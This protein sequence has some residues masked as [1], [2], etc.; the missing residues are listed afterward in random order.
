MVRGW[1]VYCRLRRRTRSVNKKVVILFSIALL[2]FANVI[3]FDGGASFG[4]LTGPSKPCSSIALKNST[5]LLGSDDKSLT[6]YRASPTF[7]FVR[8][9]RDHDNFVQVVKFRGDGKMF[10]SAGADGKVFIYSLEDNYNCKHVCVS[11]CGYLIN[12]S[13]SSPFSH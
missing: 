8:T 5:L 10:A 12:P 9:L 13:S 2:R 3:K 6:I 4:E 11:K 7:K 1:K